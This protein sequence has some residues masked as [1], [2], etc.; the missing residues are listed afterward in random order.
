MANSCLRLQILEPISFQPVQGPTLALKLVD[1][2]RSLAGWFGG[3]DT[4]WRHEGIIFKDHLRICSRFSCSGLALK[5]GQ[6]QVVSPLLRP[7]MP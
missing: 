6:S 4:C 2:V 7:W 1:I 3:H 5:A